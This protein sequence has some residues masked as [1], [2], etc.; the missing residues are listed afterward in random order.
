MVKWKKMN[1]KMAGLL[2]GVMMLF[3]ASTTA[4]AYVDESA[5]ASKVETTQTD[6]STD[7]E[8]KKDEATNTNEVLA[9]RWNRQG[10]CIYDTWQ[11]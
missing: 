5:E 9:G 1:K 2:L 8:E 6:Q 4:F 10:N 7:K 3:T 11:W